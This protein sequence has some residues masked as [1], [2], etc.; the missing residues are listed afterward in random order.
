ANEVIAPLNDAEVVRQKTVGIFGQAVRPVKWRA[1][2]DV[3]QIGMFF[4]AGGT[5]VRHA[6]VLKKGTVPVRSIDFF[7]ERSLV[8]KG[9][10]LFSRLR[11]S[12]LRS[13]R[14]HLRLTF[15][16]ASSPPSTSPPAV[17]DR[18]VDDL[19]LFRPEPIGTIRCSEPA[20]RYRR[21]EP[22]RPPGC[23]GRRCRP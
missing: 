15:V 7:A 2:A 3:R 8:G 6:L 19:C 4:A 20:P 22:H 21:T 9:K 11:G 17:P 12:Y 1:E 23:A 5:G 10:S 18:P 14:V 16:S 13:I